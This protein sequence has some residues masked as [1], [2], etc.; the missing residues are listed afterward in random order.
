LNQTIALPIRHGEGKIVF[1]GDL[2]NQA[3]LYERLINN[4]QIALTYTDDINGSYQKIAGVC[5]TSGRIF[6][7]MPHPEAATSEWLNPEGLKKSAAVG[8]GASFF[9]SGIEYCE[10]NFN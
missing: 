10:K 7:L 5:D 6:G 9:E 3:N 8:I 4:Q 1:E 2:K